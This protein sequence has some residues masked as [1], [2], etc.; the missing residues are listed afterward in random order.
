MRELM[1]FYESEE[2]KF[3]EYDEELEQLKQE[4]K[5]ES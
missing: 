5:G 3:Q 4:F 2:G 1:K